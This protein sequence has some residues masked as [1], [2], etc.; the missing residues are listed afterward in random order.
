MKLQ[1]AKDNQIFDEKKNMLEEIYQMLTIHL[2]N[3]PTN[4]I[5]R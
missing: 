2:G 3:P 4:L 5:G 1:K